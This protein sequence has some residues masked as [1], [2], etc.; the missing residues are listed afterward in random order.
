M[1]AHSLT[2]VGLRRTLHECYRPWCNPRAQ[3]S[4]IEFSCSNSPAEG[5]KC[6]SPHISPV[7]RDSAML[8]DTRGDTSSS[9][10]VSSV[11]GMCRKSRARIWALK[12]DNHIEEYCKCLSIFKHICTVGVVMQ[13]NQ[14][15]A[16]MLL[17]PLSE[18]CAALAQ[19]TAVVRPDETVHRGL[20]WL[21]VCRVAM[22]TQQISS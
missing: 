22:T 20:L 2:P 3:S 10:T 12:I 15:L 18:Q 14:W 4:I 6:T 19:R 17:F 13:E 21:S 9:L 11:L 16:G 7:G 1:N 5:V 8:D